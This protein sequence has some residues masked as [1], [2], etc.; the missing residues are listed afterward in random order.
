[1]TLEN[2]SLSDKWILEKL[3]K[4]VA[5]VRNNMEKYEYHNVGNELYS[6]IFPS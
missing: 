4:T 6:F 2:L 3:N 5:S 1:M